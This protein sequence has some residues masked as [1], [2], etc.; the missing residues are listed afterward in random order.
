MPIS[1][2]SSWLWKSVQFLCVCMHPIIICVSHL[3]CSQNHKGLM[4]AWFH[5]SDLWLLT[6]PFCGWMAFIS[7]LVLWVLHSYVQVIRFLIEQVH[8][9]YFFTSAELHIVA[10][11]L[12]LFFFNIYLFLT[13][14]INSFPFALSGSLWIQSCICLINQKDIS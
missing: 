7:F 6:Q 2:V 1:N 9:N 13:G 10:G 3:I 5:F 12:C 14:Y 8:L 4:K 11:F